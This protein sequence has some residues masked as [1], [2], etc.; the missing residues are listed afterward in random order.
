MQFAPSEHVDLKPAPQK[1]KILVLTNKLKNLITI[2]D[3]MSKMI[4]MEF[5]QEKKK[6]ISNRNNDVVDIFFIAINYI[7]LSFNF[8]FKNLK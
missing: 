4:S 7:M 2:T 3:F 5:I 8:N 6:F 1:I